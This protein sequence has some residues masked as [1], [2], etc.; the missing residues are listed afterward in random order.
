M[1]PC[2]PKLCDKNI[3]ILRGEYDDIIPA[4]STNRLEDI[5]TT[6]GADVTVRNIDA[7]HEIT[8]LDIAVI[9]EWL[10][11]PPDH[12]QN[13]DMLVQKA[14]ELINEANQSMR[15]LTVSMGQISNDSKETGK[16]IKTIDEIAFQTNLLALNAAVEAARAGQAGAGFTVVADEVRNLAIR[17]ANAGEAASAC[18]EMKTQA[19]EMKRMVAVL[20][21]MVC[22]KSNDNN[23]SFGSTKKV[24]EDTSTVEAH[25]LMNHAKPKEIRPLQVIPFGDNEF[26]DF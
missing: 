22:D 23:E 10:A 6:A 5:L 2:V 4:K 17:A 21:A 3:L 20:A 7:G 1:N 12:A 11:D 19:Q 18:E 26:K 9:S 24:L 15:E 13:A 14:H 16:I 8:P 25:Q